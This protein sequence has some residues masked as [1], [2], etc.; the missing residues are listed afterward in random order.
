MRGEGIGLAVIGCGTIGRVRAELAREHPS[1]GW[2]GLCDRDP[3]V[4]AKLLAADTEAD[5]ADDRFLA[6]WWRG[7]E[8]DDRRRRD[9]RE[10]AHHDPILASVEHGHT[11][12]HREAA[13]HRPGRVRP[14]SSRPSRTTASMPSSAIR[15]GSGGASSPR[16]SGFATARSAT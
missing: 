11:A 3:D 2:L 8:V 15:N 5:C 16:G 10:L 4:M 9:R 6:A 13:R 1:I 14:R 7:P 12:L